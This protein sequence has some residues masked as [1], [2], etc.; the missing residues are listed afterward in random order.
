MLHVQSRDQKA[1]EEGENF[2]GKNAGLRVVANQI[3]LDSFEK[4]LLVGQVGLD[5]TTALLEDLRHDL[6]PQLVRRVCEHVSH[7]QYDAV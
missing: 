5:L 2:E 3:V 4:H 1:G 7:F 6:R